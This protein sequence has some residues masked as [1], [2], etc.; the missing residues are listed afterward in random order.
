MS[1]FS[2][3]QATADAC[4]RAALRAGA[5]DA[6]AHGLVALILALLL[7][8]LGGAAATWDRFPED[9]EYGDE[10][11]QFPAWR[12]A[13]GR[14]ALVMPPMGRAPHAA[15]IEAGLAPDWVLPGV[16]N[17]GMRPSRVPVRSRPRALRLCAASVRAPPAARLSPPGTSIL[18]DSP[19]KIP[20][21]L[22]APFRARI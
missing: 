15:C 1:H 3:P 7:R 16:I 19:L 2:A 6:R 17:R 18:E 12:Y 11:A 8:L 20:S 13:E 5:V 21:G 14:H 4:L 22:R 10:V 9:D